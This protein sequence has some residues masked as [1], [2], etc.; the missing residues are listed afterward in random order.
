MFQKDSNI[1]KFQRR[2]TK[3]YEFSVKF[4]TI[5]YTRILLLYYASIKVKFK[6]F[7][8]FATVSLFWL[9]FPENAIV[10][11]HHTVNES[12]TKFLLYIAFTNS[13]S[14]YPKN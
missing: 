5:F 14:A 13:P 6:Q 9:I 3:A 4:N 11:S 7:K 8:Q 2:F 1:I 12:K 10:S